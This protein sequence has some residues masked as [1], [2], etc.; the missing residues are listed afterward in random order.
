MLPPS[1]GTV[2]FYPCVLTVDY[3]GETYSLAN[4]YSLL[5]NV[6]VITSEIRV[7]DLSEKSIDSKPVK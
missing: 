6:M 7:P 5:K 2:V 3:N 1:V 4:G